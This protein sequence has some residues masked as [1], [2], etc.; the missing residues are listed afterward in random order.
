MGSRSYKISMTNSPW[1]S[2]GNCTPPIWTA[3]S[4]M[5]TRKVLLF[6]DSL[7]LQHSV[8][9]IKHKYIFCSIIKMKVYL[10]R[11]K[12]TPREEHEVQPEFSYMDLKTFWYGLEEGN[13]PRQEINI[14]IHGAIQTYH[15]LPLALRLTPGKGF[16]K[17]FSC[18]SSF[19][20]WVNKWSYY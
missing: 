1:V 14:N 18:P 7:Q 19:M 8:L 12:G 6:P 15:M 2:K 9:N 16:T 10:S 3:P 11:C 4:F 17:F 5:D 13:Y 20:V